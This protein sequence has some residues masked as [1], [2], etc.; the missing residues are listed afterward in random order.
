MINLQ[1][2]SRISLDKDGSNL[3][4]I[5]IGLN[6]GQIINSSFFGLVKSGVNVDL[7]GSVSMFDGTKGVI[8]TVY[9]RQLVSKDG[10]VQHSGDD[11]T[12]D[13][14][15]DEKDNELIYINLEKVSK[16]VS[17]I[18]I[19]LNS[20][21]KQDFADVPYSKIR[22]IE[23]TLTNIKSVFAQFDLSADKKFAGY[24]SMILGKL[25]RSGS[26]W[27]F[28]AIGEPIKALDISQT[29]KT[30]QADFL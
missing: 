18:V 12:G 16:V 4:E 9:Y 14:V 20:F 5:C 23:G 1:K 7:D 3:K 21:N 19:Y 24:T 2:N 28:V 30:I 27:E 11:R 6:W 10:A 29:I 25:L 15:T 26:G 22:I 13:T 17:T 8:D